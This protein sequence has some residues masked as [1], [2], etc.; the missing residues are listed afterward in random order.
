MNALEDLDIVEAL[1]RAAQAGV[2]I[3]LIVRDTCRLRPGRSGLSETVTVAASVGASRTS[4]YYFRN[5]GDE[6]FFLG[7]P[8]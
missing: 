3:E 8:T 1:Y 6:E 4:I 5:G 2:R 7:W